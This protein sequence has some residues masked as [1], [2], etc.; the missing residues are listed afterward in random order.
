MKDDKKTDVYS[1]VKWNGNLKEFQEDTYVFQAGD[2]VYNNKCVNTIQR[3]CHWYTPSTT[4][5]VLHIQHVLAYKIEFKKPSLYINI[6]N[7]C[8]SR[9]T[10]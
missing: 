9:E 7:T 1:V 3:A 8:N 5:T 2:V 10:E 6:P 4:K